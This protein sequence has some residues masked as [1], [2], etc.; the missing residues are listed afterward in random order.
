MTDPGGR[1][2]F[3]GLDRD[4]YRIWAGSPGHAIASVA[5]VLVGDG[6]VDDL[7]L[8]LLDGIRIEGAVRSVDGGE[9]PDATIVAVSDIEVGGLARSRGNRQGRFELEDL[10]DGVY[11]VYATAPGYASGTAKE[12]WPGPRSRSSWSRE[13]C[14]PAR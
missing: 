4:R 12:V 6:R 9:V 11:Y 2:T 8:V 13:E 3:A 14:S 10:A 5:R 1:F 7:E